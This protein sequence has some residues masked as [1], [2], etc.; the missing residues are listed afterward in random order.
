MR[1]RVTDPR[2]VA[3]LLAS[4][5]DGRERGAYARL[6]VVDADPDAEPAPD[7]P[8]AYGVAVDGE[9][10]ATVRLYPDAAT[11]EGDAALAEFAADEDLPVD[12]TTVSV[13]D[14]A[15]VKRVARLLAERATL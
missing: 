14:G 10:V 5:L 13:P 7:G 1:E 12:G 3:E 4:E 2:R 11:V 8:A 9:R 6:A 15:A